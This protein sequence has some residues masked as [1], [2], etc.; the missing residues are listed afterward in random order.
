MKQYS[1]DFKVRVI[2]E[3]LSGKYGGMDRVARRNNISKTNLNQWIL[4]Y[5]IFGIDHFYEKKEKTKYTMEFKAHVIQYKQD[6]NLTHS[7]TTK[8]FKLSSHSLVYKWEKSGIKGEYSKK[9]NALNPMINNEKQNTKKKLNE[10]E[11][12]EL[13]RLR[14]ENKKLTEELRLSNMKIAYEK[15]LQALLIEE[16][17]QAKQRQY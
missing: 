9:G 2:K 3:Y 17:L 14:E 12:E 1:P 10:T 13:L 11:S 5:K 16:E 15:K 6:H 4:N 8:L 7:E